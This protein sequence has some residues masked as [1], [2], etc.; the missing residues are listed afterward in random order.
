MRFIGLL[1]LLVSLT[2]CKD[3]GEA[4]T[5]ESPATK[6]DEKSGD[7]KAKLETYEVRGRF[8][9]FDKAAG[10]AAIHHE[11]IPEFKNREGQKSGMMSMQMEFRVDAGVSVDGLAKNAPVR[12]RFTVDWDK[13]PAIGIVELEKLPDD[14]ELQL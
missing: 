13:K 5:G 10:L 9:G 12:I 1:A 7:D 11:A 14:T 2:A 8:V 3:K 6:K 4:D